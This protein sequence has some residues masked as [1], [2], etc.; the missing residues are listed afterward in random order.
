MVSVKK[1]SPL[2]AMKDYGELNA[3]IHIFPAAASWR[4]IVASPTHGPFYPWKAPVLILEK[5]E[6]TPGPVWYVV[7]K[8]NLW[9]F[10]YQRNALSWLVLKFHRE[11]FYPGPGIELGPLAL[12]ASALPLRH[13]GQL[14]IQGRINLFVP[15]LSDL[16]TTTNSVVAT[17]YRGMHSN[18]WMP[19]T[20]KNI[21]CL[22]PLNH[23]FS[24]LHR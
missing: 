6:W 9:K 5:A 24:L 17:S 7:V 22:R 10:D 2:H 21:S 16:R 23:K 18:I 4:G 12:R 13:P 1:S 3:R 15:I 14:P 8:K 20:E 11:K 19:N